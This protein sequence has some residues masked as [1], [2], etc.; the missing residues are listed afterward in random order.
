MRNNGENGLAQLATRT[1][2]L[3]YLY[4]FAALPAMPRSRYKYLEGLLGSFTFPTEREAPWRLSE[5]LY[6]YYHIYLYK[7]T[8]IIS[9]FN[10]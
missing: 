9:M 8:G 5:Q 7:Y 10:K 2:Y 1:V 3:H 4:I 6:K